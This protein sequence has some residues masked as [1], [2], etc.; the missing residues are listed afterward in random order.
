MCHE[1]HM[2]ANEALRICCACG[3]GIKAVPG[4][5]SPNKTASAGAVFSGVP[6]LLFLVCGRVV[7]CPNHGCRAVLPAR[8]AQLSLPDCPVSAVRTP[9]QHKVA[10]PGARVCW[11]C[12]ARCGTGLFYSA[13]IVACVLFMVGFAFLTTRK[14][15]GR[16]F[17]K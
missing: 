17:S 3:G 15:G 16:S 7:E 8:C 6:L 9:L 1:D 12:G 14:S 10:C 11:S 4:N 2:E 5:G 13:V